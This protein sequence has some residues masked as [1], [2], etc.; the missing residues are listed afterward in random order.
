MGWIRGLVACRK[1]IAG[2]ARVLLCKNSRVQ[3][4]AEVGGE[5]LYAIAGRFDP[6]TEFVERFDDVGYV[7]RTVDARNGGNDDAWGDSGTITSFRFIRHVTMGL[8]IDAS[9]YEQVKRRDTENDLVARVESLASETEQDEETRLLVMRFD[10]QEEST[11][12]D[13]EEAADAIRS[14][15]DFLTE[16]GVWHGGSIIHEPGEGPEEI[17]NITSGDDDDMERFE[18]GTELLY[19]GPSASASVQ[20]DTDDVGHDLTVNDGGF[21][22]YG[23]GDIEIRVDDDD[24]DGAA[25]DGADDGGDAGASAPS[26]AGNASLSGLDFG[27]PPGAT[28]NPATTPDN[29]GTSFRSGGDWNE[30][31]PIGARESTH[32]RGGHDDERKP[33]GEGGKRPAVE[34]VKRDVQRTT[35]PPPLPTASHALQPTGK[36]TNWIGIIIVASLAIAGL[37]YAYSRLIAPLGGPTQPL[38][39][40]TSGIPTQGPTVPGIPTGTV[41]AETTAATALSNPSFDCATASGIIQKTICADAR[42][43]E[44]DRTLYEKYRQLQETGSG[45][46]A[47][48]STQQ[49]WLAMRNT[50]ADTDCLAD[51]YRSRIRE[52]EGIALQVPRQVTDETP[53]ARMDANLAKPSSNP[54]F[55][56]ATHQ[57]LIEQAICGDPELGDLHREM[58]QKYSALL[59]AGADA[60]VMKASQDFWMESR[61]RCTDKACL[62]DAYMSRIR[63]MDEYAQSKR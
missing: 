57:S 17:G 52:L 16:H 47:L 23:D 9:A 60:T 18:R 1:N 43:G 28:T 10:I 46:P 21:E 26:A 24:F 30:P 6:G 48:A 31:P 25:D 40:A 7:I 19:I 8:V 13:I 11:S 58:T 37:M 63:A 4:V 2:E 5:V 29:P 39:P 12:Y 42:L 33:K 54:G 34:T 36:P 49:L 14:F 41:P 62:V 35:L 59:Y 38:V 3:Q 51:T 56:C 22:Y 45:N 27:E 50:C 44:L 55:D 53:Q 20:W 61:E 32:Q 15:S